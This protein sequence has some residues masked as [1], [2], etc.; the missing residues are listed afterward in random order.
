MFIKFDRLGDKPK[1]AELREEI[2]TKTVEVTE[3]SFLMGEETKDI[4]RKFSVDDSFV[5]S[6]YFIFSPLLPS[7]LHYLFSAVSQEQRAQSLS[8]NSYKTKLQ[9]SDADKTWLEGIVNAEMISYLA[10]CH[11]ILGTL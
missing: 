4:V 8:V 2:S 9:I 10:W 5:D 7:L 3:D 6:F 11:K 1:N